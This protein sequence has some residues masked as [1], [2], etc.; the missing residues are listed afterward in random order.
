MIEYQ[1]NSSDKVLAAA[2]TLVTWG[3]ELLELADT[4]P[5]TTW[6]KQFEAWANRY[7]I[8]AAE[9]G[10]PTVIPAGMSKVRREV[11]ASEYVVSFYA[12]R[13]MR[14]AVLMLQDMFV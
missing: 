7:N 9:I 11:D 10:E 6:F 13:W 5:P 1:R 12:A 2:P 14:A 3:E 4:L 8:T